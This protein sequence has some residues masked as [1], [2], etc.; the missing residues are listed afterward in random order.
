MNGGRYRACGFIFVFLFLVGLFKN[1]I[2]CVKNL[3]TIKSNQ[4]INIIKK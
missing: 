2:D 4:H 1:E 3:I